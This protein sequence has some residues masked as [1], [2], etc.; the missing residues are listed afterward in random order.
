MTKEEQLQQKLI[1]D[2]QKE[3][4]QA[5]A[6]AKKEKMMQIEAEKRKNVPLS[7]QEQEEQ[8]KATGL[9]N[10][11]LIKLLMNR[12]I[13]TCLK[14]QEIMNEGLDEVKHMNQMMVYSKC[15]TIR[16]KQ[17]EEKKKI[18]EMKK[19]EEKRK[20]LMMEIDRLKLIKKIEE[21]E[22]AKKDELRKGHHQIIDQIKENEMK[23]L[24]ALEEQE[25]E[26]QT[27]IQGMKQLQQ[28]EAQN[29]VVISSHHRTRSL[30]FHVII[31][32]RNIKLKSYWMRFIPPIRTQLKVKK[33]RFL[34]KRKKRRE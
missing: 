1:L 6:K 2:E 27:I 10:R 26:G 23:R 21:D 24:K 3:K 20:D 19:T 18:E 11:V 9:K 28:E 14:A 17:L 33:L 4:Q 22:R 32:K 8:Q 15:V 16:D 12:C 30:S 7:E 13:K 29:A 31:R 5:A 25:Q 34:L